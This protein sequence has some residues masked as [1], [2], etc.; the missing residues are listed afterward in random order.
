MSFLAKIKSLE[1]QKTKL[2]EKRQ[3]EILKTIVDSKTLEFDNKILASFMKFLG[4]PENKDHPF[5]LELKQLLI[6]KGKVPSRSSKALE[7]A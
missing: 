5:I 1:E 2:I 4:K 3:Q 7:P 6:V